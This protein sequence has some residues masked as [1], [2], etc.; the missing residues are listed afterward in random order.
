M[1]WVQGLNVS[2]PNFLAKGG[3]T[4]GLGARGSFSVPEF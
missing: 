4:D 3:K 1:H 2:V